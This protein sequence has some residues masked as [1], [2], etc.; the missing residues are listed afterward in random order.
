M[1]EPLAADGLEGA[2]IGLGT[3][4]PRV[5]L[6]Y[7]LAAVRELLVNQGCPEEEVDEHI[8]FNI[9]G[10]WGGQGTPVFVE[11]MSVEEVRQRLK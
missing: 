1:T 3:Q 5:M 9:L 7:D 2:L 6:V 4:G 11:R 10:A 8:A